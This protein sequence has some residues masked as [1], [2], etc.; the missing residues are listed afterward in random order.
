MTALSMS[1]NFVGVTNNPGT[2][3]TFM[4]RNNSAD[5]SGLGVNW[6]ATTRDASGPI[7]PFTKP[8]PM[9]F[10]T[11]GGAKY[12]RNDNI[13]N[14]TGAFKQVD[15]A[16]CSADPHPVIVGV[17][18]LRRGSCVPSGGLPA[19]S[20]PGHFV[21]VTGKQIDSNGV[22]HY[23]I[24]DPGCRS[25]TSLDVFN[26]EFVT[27]GIVR[28]PPGDIS[29]LDIAVNGAADIMVADPSGNLTGRDLNA[30]AIVQA[31][32][33]SAYFS[34]SIDDEFNGVPA[35]DVV[36]QVPIFQPQQGA[37]NVNVNGTKLATYSLSVRAF[38]QDGSAQPD[39]V[40]PGIEGPGSMTLYQ[41]QF[42][43]SPGSVSNA[44]LIASFVSTLA[45]INNSLQLGLIDNPGVANSLS[46][47]I[48]AAQKATGSARINILN[49]FINEVNAQ[50]E[51]HVTGV[52]VE[53]LLQDAA[54]LISQNGS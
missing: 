1:L 34:D 41:V 18:G 20:A 28:D 9:R 42:I 30:G 25:N 51:K 13:L 33:G 19:P 12:S 23:S 38:S 15:D 43:S 53:V 52:T 31:I 32:P 39:I 45:D 27:R 49:A 37:F 6:D 40:L 29:Q 16:L 7:S 8:K 4:S 36:R 44:T 22:P 3:N 35:I 47:K 24:I 54:S 48:S 21:L 50:A 26:N 46:K 10:D 5:F 2:L 17:A 14:P 11:L